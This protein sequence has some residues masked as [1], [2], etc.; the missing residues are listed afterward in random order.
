MNDKGLQFLSKAG[1]C[2]FLSIGIG[3]LLIAF[4]V[5]IN[6]LINL[7][8]YEFVE[9]QVVSTKS[10]G[11]STKVPSFDLTVKYK[12]T[13]STVTSST[14]MCFTRFD[15]GEKVSIYFNPNSP[16]EFIVNHFFT[17]WMIPAF[18]YFIG[19][20]WVIPFLKDAIR[21]RKN[22]YGNII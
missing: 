8:R 14:N 17:I 20:C 10:S 1:G 18:F 15:T 12:T 13:K 3:F 5:T 22:K 9:G 19:L 4:L 21:N 6:N 16:R 7:S 2:L 11:N